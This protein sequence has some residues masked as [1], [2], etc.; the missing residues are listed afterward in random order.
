MASDEGDIS[1]AALEFRPENRMRALIIEPQVF[2]SFMIEDVLRD[3]GYTS[4]ATATT[5]E[6]AVAAAEADPPD[7]VTSAVQLQDGSGIRAV[8]RIRSACD[9]PVLFIT[10]EV[11]EVSA[12]APALPIVKKPFLKSHLAPAVEEATRRSSRPSG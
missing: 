1:P 2:T 6:E 8:E 5:E 4:I 9:V 7:L 12:R 3:A 11:V 10:Q